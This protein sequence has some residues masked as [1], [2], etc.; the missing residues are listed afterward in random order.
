MRK[1]LGIALCLLLA[2]GNASAAVS[3]RMEDT[4]ALLDSDGA[5]IV[6]PGLYSDIVSLGE[7]LFAAGDAGRFA[8]MNGAGE[9]LTDAVYELFHLEDGMLLAK[10]DG[11]WGMLGPDGAELSTFEFGQIVPTG[12]GGCWALRGDADDMESDLLCLLDASGA[13]TSTGVYVRKM[14]REASEGLLP[15]LLPGSGLWGY[16]DAQGAVCIAAA[17]SYAGNFASGRAVVVLNGRYGAIDAEGRAVTEPDYDFM[18]ISP[19]GFIL[20]ARAREGAWV[21]DLNGREIA[22]Y[23]GENG[24]AALVGDGYSVADA[25]ALRVYDAS[26]ALR[27]EVDPEAAVYE[28]LNGQLILSEG[29]WGEACVYIL[30][31]QERYQN[32]YPLGSAGGTGVYACMEAPAARYVNDLLG[33]VQISVDMDA[34]LYGLVDASGAQRLPCAYAS[35]EFLGEE[36][37]LARD[38]ALWRVI[39]LDGKLYWSHPITKTEAPSS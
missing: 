14:G 18:E 28:G 30:G 23:A 35:I 27:V 10:R 24:F 11:Y 25:D 6:A 37:F 2:L 8:L 9:R 31:T 32:L 39:D 20:A 29:M 5:E 1:I 33:E 38:D 19:A 15:V 36:R 13:E 22:A 4:A 21:L 7:N 34:A 17:Y 16:C 26:G 3:V 12:A